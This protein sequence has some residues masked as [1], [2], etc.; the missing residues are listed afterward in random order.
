MK[1][2]R[3]VFSVTPRPIDFPKILIFPNFFQKFQKKKCLKIEIGQSLPS[4][5]NNK[6]GSR[7]KATLPD[8][9]TKTEFVRSQSF[10]EI[11]GA[12]MDGA[13]G[14]S[15]PEHS[16]RMDKSE[17]FSPLVNDPNKWWIPNWQSRRRVFKLINL[18]F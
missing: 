4:L 7:K 13:S 1:N 17:E 6:N 12:S 16:D 8:I 5:I 15:N 10:T 2:F 11:N 9:N 3:T 18:A 14:E